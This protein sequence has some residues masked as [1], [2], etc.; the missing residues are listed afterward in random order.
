MNN[1][2]SMLKTNSKAP[3]DLKNKSIKGLDTK[4]R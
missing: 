2:T 3:Y 1:M 4:E